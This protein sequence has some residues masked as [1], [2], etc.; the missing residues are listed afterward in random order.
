MLAASGKLDRRAVVNALLA[1]RGDLLVIAGLSG[2]FSIGVL[3]KSQ[4]ADLLR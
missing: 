4:P 3:K 1:D 2:L